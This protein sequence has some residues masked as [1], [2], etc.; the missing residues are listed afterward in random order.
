[1]KLVSYWTYLYLQN[2]MKVD[3]LLDSIGIHQKHQM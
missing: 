2:R 1:L 3:I